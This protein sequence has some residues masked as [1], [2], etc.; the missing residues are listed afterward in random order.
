MVLVQKEVKK[1][2]IWKEPVIVSDMKWPCPNGFHVPLQSEFNSII[3][4]WNHLW[5]GWNTLY[6]DCFKMPYQWQRLYTN[7][8]VW[9]TTY[10]YYW[11][12][13][14]E[15]S[16]KA[17]CYYFNNTYTYWVWVYVPSWCAI[18]PFK[19]SP[20]T[21]TASWTK[22]YWTSIEAWGIFW[23]ATDWLISVSEDWQ[24]WYTIMD[25]N[26]GATQ[27]YNDWDTLSQ[28]NCGNFYQRWNNYW[29]PYSWTVTTSST[30]INATDYWPWNY[31][32]SSTF[33]TRSSSPYGWDS[34]NNQNLWW[35]VNKWTHT[36]WWWD[37]QIR[38][39]T[40]A[41]SIT[42]DKST[43]ALTSAWQ[44]EQLTATIKPK[45][46]THKKAL[47]SSSDTSIATVDSN[48]LVTCVTP[49][50]C[51]ITASTFN[52]EAS[53][54][55]NVVQKLTTTDVVV[56][57]YSNTSTASWTY[58]WVNFTALKSWSIKKVSLLYPSTTSWTLY[59]V[60]WSFANSPWWTSYTLNTSN[61]I[62]WEYTLTTP[63]NIEQWK[64]YTVCINAY[65]WYYNW[66][67][68]YP[69]TREAVQY[70]YTT[71]WWNQYRQY[72]YAIKSLTIDY[73]P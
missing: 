69:L 60:E 73:V 15:W 40:Y 41:E 43:I 58:Y 32:E 3:S 1:V 71:A 20:I 53:T 5:A 9:N 11:T 8:T 35:W 19:D 63:F 4:I 21:P 61:T 31:Y 38:P 59:I 10:G 27:V 17:V 68:W 22:L 56:Y 37:I 18:R 62:D 16:Y 46:A 30:Q 50:E 34:S 64:Y 2:Y 51:V 6:K 65:F 26:L 72:V 44:T 25:K 12:S 13:S 49:W 36:E 39:I 28:A 54:T 66:S 47:W 52:W 70:N 7:S 57:N 42:L 14:Y 24:T 33:I 55:C 29:F 45:N 23:S 67:P 48:W